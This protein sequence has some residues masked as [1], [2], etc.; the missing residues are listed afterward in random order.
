MAKKNFYTVKNGRIPG[1][2]KTWE[3]CKEQVQGY[4]GAVFKGFE[5]LDEAEAFLGNS[6]SKTVLDKTDKEEAIKA[7]KDRPED[8]I[9]YVD[10]SYHQATG[11]FSCGVVFLWNGK[12]IHLKEKYEDSELSS[13]RNVAGEIKGAELAMKYAME[14]QI[15]NL[16]IYHDYQG[17]A[18]WCTGEWQTKKEGT[19]AYRNF[20]LEASRV[21]QITFYKVKGHSGVKYNEIADQLAKQA[22]GLL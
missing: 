17:I 16:A 1:I 20:Y 19:R 9:A 2:Y 3:D 18:S 21:I 7:S 13:M 11:A 5:T 14:H 4:P 10:G 6:Q 22:L 12:E 8:A 15:P